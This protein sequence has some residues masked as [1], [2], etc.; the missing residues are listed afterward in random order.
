MCHLFG[1]SPGG[2]V[3]AS[4]FPSAFQHFCLA[5]LRSCRVAATY[6]RVAATK[7]ERTL[8][9]CCV[10]PCQLATPPRVLKSTT[11]PAGTLYKTNRFGG[12]P[13][14]PPRSAR[15]LDGCDRKPSQRRRPHGQRWLSY[16]PRRMHAHTP[17]C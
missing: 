2:Y 7:E 6:V 11:T 3:R 15:F 17:C 16:Q 8:T 5:I 1:Y 4:L 12:P 13:V 14:V 9:Y 10:F